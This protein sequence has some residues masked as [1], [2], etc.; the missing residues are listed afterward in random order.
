MIDH[1]SIDFL[2]GGSKLLGGIGSTVNE[3]E[4]KYYI[5]YGLG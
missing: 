2:L 5:F 4:G 3:F 1:N